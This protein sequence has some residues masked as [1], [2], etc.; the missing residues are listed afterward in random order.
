MF[1]VRQNLSL[2]LFSIEKIDAH[3]PAKACYLLQEISGDESCRA[4]RRSSL[5]EYLV[6]HSDAAKSVGEG[7]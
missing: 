4:L 1:V 2:S 3:P 5:L 6:L 7:A